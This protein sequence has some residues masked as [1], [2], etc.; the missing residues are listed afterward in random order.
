MPLPGRCLNVKSELHQVA[1][2]INITAVCDV[3][4]AD[5]NTV[6]ENLVDHSEFAA[7]GRVATLQLIT[8]RLSN[9]M[10]IVGEWATDE[11]PTRYSHRLRQDVS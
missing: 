3:D 4:Y 8:Q 11:F 9:S 10:R 2:P 1:S 5:D 7:P 6:V